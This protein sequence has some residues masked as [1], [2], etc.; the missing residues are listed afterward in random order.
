MAEIWLLL[1]LLEILE[2]QLE[3]QLVEVPPEVAEVRPEVADFGT[4][5]LM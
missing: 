1:K 2:R 5:Q 4:E 3:S